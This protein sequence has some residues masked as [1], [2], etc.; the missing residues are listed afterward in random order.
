MFPP[1]RV[2]ELEQS[3]SLLFCVRSMRRCGIK[4]SLALKKKNEHTLITLIVDE[5][6][7]GTLAVSLGGAEALP[8]P[9]GDGL[10]IG[11]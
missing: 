7:I 1:P 5:D 9:S 6:A 10:T 3:S 8:D 2:G 4:R 11:G